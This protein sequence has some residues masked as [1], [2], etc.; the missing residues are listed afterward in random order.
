MCAWKALERDDARLGGDDAGEVRAD[1]APIA[2]GDAGAV[3]RQRAAESEGQAVRAAR[4]PAPGLSADFAATG[5]EERQ[6]Y[7]EGAG[8]AGGPCARRR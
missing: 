4:A 6:G 7:V 1:H 8:K 2:G 5:S 3:G